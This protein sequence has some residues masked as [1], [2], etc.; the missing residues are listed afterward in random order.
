M[1]VRQR[2]IDKANGPIREMAIKRVKAKIAQQNGRIED[3][4]EDE[5][6]DLVAAEE[7]TIKRRLWLLPYG[8]LLALL[9]I[10]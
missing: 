6:E 8:A 9:G 1:S 4:T 7:A 2:I 5:R 3:Y 10:A